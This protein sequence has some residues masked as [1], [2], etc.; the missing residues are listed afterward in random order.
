[1]TNTDKLTL[2]I[3]KEL[4]KVVTQEAKRIGISKNAFILSLLWKMSSERQINKWGGG[5]NGTNEPGII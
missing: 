2:R 3:P 5:T 1:M 4:N